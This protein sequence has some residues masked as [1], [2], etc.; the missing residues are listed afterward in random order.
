MIDLNIFYTTLDAGDGTLM[1]V[2]NNLFF[3]KVLRRR[4]AARAV[5]LATHIRTKHPDTPNGAAVA[6]KHVTVQD[7]PNGL[8][9]EPALPVS[10]T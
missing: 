1:Q 9:A 3:Q 2:P 10:G 4:P 5:P 7:T 8:P 6:D